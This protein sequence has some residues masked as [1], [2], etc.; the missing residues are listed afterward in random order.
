MGKFDTRW[1]SFV[2]YAES[3]VYTENGIYDA[4]ETVPTFEHEGTPNDMTQPMHSVFGRRYIEWKAEC[5]ADPLR[6]PHR[7]AEERNSMQEIHEQ[8]L[9]LTI[10]AAVV[11]AV[12]GLFYPCLT[13]CCQC[14]GPS[15][16]NSYKLFLSSKGVASFLLVGGFS[17][18]LGVFIQKPYKFNSNFKDSDCSDALTNSLIWEGDESVDHAFAFEALSFISLAVLLMIEMVMAGYYCCLKD[19]K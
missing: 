12:V 8:L 11:F 7:L 2:T 19:Y 18:V 13:C 9:I 1:K 6:S 5:V 17:V 16:I 14:C 3:G 4:L 15:N 10:I